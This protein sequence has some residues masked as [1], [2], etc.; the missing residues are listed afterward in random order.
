MHPLFNFHTS[1]TVPLVAASKP[2]WLNERLPAPIPILYD[3]SGLYVRRSQIFNFLSI[4]EVA[5]YLQ[6]KILISILYTCKTL[7]SSC[8]YLG[9]AQISYFF[10]TLCIYFLTVSFVHVVSI[11]TDFQQNCLSL[12]GIL[13]ILKGQQL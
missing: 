8:F 1:T 3:W 5:I 9:N 7:K 12:W 2:V 6:H 13:T 11:F 4:P 10:P